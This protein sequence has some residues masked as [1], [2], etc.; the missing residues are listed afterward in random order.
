MDRRITPANDRAALESLRGRVDAPRYTTGEPAQVTL[1]LADL[2]KSPAGARDRQL[3]L[4]ETFTVIDRHDGHAF[5]QSVKDGYCGYL[6]ETALAP[7][8]VPSH[9]VAAPATHLYPE[10]RL[11]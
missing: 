2:L 11:Q 10:P 3:L 4:G 1:P 7:Q 5:G 6:P 9:W 8:E